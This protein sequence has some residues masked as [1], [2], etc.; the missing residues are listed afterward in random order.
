MRNPFFTL[1]Q[2][3]GQPYQVERN[4]T[5]LATHDGLSNRT[6]GTL[7]D[8][9][10]FMPGTDVQPNDW[11]INQFGERFYVQ[12]TKTTVF[13]KEPHEIQA[14]TLSKVE[15]EKLH[16]N[17]SKSTFHINNAY[18][19]VI[20]NQ[21]NFTMNYSSSINELRE[22]INDSQSSDKEELSKIIDLLEMITNNQL[23]VSKGIFSKFS[24]VMQRN[25]WI[26]NNIAS[27]LLNWMTT[28]M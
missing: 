25:S 21:S 2:R 4:G 18:G 15:Y 13:M 10:G 19:S 22:T 6:N 16:N 1:L 27:I 9:V 26:T 20:G 11:L 28:Q 17:N 12:D 23:P 24:E 14:F 8:Y 7:K 5:I 3:T